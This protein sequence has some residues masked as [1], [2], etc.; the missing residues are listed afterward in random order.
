MKN[1][2]NIKSTKNKQNSFD[3]LKDHIN[4]EYWSNI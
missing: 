4:Q 3:E 2:E 1:R